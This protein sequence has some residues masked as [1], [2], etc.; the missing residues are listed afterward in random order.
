MPVLDALA[1]YEPLVEAD[2]EL[3][4]SGHIVSFLHDTYVLTCRA[5]ARVV[6]EQVSGIIKRWAGVKSHLGK[7]QNVWEGNHSA[8]ERVF[9]RHLIWVMLKF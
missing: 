5:R 9:K 8:V 6:Y 4:P 2:G 3:L 1:Q 7:L